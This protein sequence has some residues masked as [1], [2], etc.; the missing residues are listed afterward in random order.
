MKDLFIRAASGALYI[1]ILLG[2]LFISQLAFI[3]VIFTLGVITCIEFSK[4]R[5]FSWILGLPLLFSVF[6]GIHYFFNEES[7]ISLLVVVN[8]ALMNIYM[9]YWLF[10]KEAAL[11]RL[12][13][14]LVFIATIV[15]G[16]GAISLIPFDHGVFRKEVMIGVLAMLWANDTFA[17]LV[18]KNFGKT[19]LMPSVSPNKTIEGLVGGALGAIIVGIVTWY[20]CKTFGLTQWIILSLIVVFFGSIGDLVQSRIKR[21]A[22]VKDSGM[23]MPG[24]GGMY[25]RLDSLI[26]AAP[27]VFLYLF[28]ISYVS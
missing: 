5:D 2:S 14:G 7:F 23:I 10:R 24:H 18:G 26:F 11:S 6:T 21:I 16:F 19:K 4:L 25:D 27:F 20:L 1:S 13:G 15:F 3:I 28:L 22:G 12:Q 8:A 17:Y 9:I